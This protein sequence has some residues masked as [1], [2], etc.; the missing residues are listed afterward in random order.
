MD[1]QPLPSS[2]RGKNVQQV[3]TVRPF[4]KTSEISF[5]TMPK[6]MLKNINLLEVI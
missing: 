1:A 2:A 3:E 5:N 6:T 4:R